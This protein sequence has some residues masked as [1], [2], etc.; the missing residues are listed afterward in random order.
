MKKLIFLFL[1]GLFFFSAAYS[2]MS[3][4]GKQIASIN[5]VPSKLENHSD[6]GNTSLHDFVTP[7]L[8]YKPRPLWFWNNVTVTPEGISEQMLN[9]RDKCGYGGLGILPFGSNFKPKYLEEDYF[10]VYGVA[11]ENAK[12]LGM[13][14]CLYDEYGFPSGSAGAINGDIDI[15]FF[16]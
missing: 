5:S 15:N 16:I 7:P 14:L 3:N 2:R 1:S 9:L 6:S 8:Q 11:L 4:S 12:K 10:K 13:K